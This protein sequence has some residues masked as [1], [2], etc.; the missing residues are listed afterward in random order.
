MADTRLAGSIIARIAGSFG[1]R[2]R[3][4]ARPGVGRRRIDRAPFRR[5]RAV[6]WNGKDLSAYSIS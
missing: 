6:I 5:H 4:P 3:G 1:W 2:G